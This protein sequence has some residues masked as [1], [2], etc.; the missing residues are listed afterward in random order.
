MN[1]KQVVRNLAYQLEAATTI[2]AACQ[3]DGI[4][5][6]ALKYV[7]KNSVNVEQMAALGRELANTLA[8][9]GH[10][11]RARNLKQVCNDALHLTAHIIRM[12]EARR[13]SA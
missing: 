13:L 11:E 1:R 4:R 3:Y 7:H 9:N 8:N 6:E 5:P 2:V 12:K 10:S